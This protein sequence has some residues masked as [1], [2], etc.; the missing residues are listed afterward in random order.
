MLKY[1]FR[2]GLAAATLTVLTAAFVG[3][4]SAANLVQNGDF[5]SPGAAGAQLLTSG[6][7]FVTDW[8]NQDKTTGYI[9]KGQTADQNWSGVLFGSAGP[10]YG[11]PNGLVGPPSGDAQVAL[12]AAFG[13]GTGGGAFGSIE[14]TISGLVPGQTYT[15]SFWQAGSEEFFGGIEPE[16][17]FFSASLGDQGVARSPTMDVSAYGF[18]PWQE[19]STTFTW[20]GS[21]NSLQISALASGNEIRSTE[22][23]FVLLADVSLTGPTVA[24]PEPSTWAMVIA[25]FA[26]LGLLARARRKGVAVA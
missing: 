25:G 6:S 5:N 22:P 20:N 12:D 1:S 7:T 17:E 23:A 24:A 19:Y 26:G 13:L 11:V 3:G 18:A 10:G 15:L 9:P 14:Q 2:V 16:I 8:T 21:G 4:A